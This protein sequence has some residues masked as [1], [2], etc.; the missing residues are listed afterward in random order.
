[1]ESDATTDALIS[2]IQSYIGLG[3]LR[4]AELVCQH[5]L[6]E[7]G[8]AQARGWFLLGLIHLH[9]KAWHEAEIALERAISLDEHS[10]ECWHNLSSA[11]E[12]Q[13]RFSEAESCS[14]RALALDPTNADYWFGLGI[15]LS[16]QLKWDEASEAFRGAVHQNPRDIGAWCNLG[17]AEQ[18][19][20]RLQ[21][22]KV[23]Y[24]RGLAL[25]PHHMDTLVNYA[26]LLAV[27]GQAQRSIDVFRVVLE[28][29]PTDREALHNLAL[30]LLLQGRLSEAEDLA[31]RLLGLDDQSSKAW[32]LTGAI[33]MAIGRTEEGLRAYQ[34]SLELGHQP[35]HHSKLLLAL[36][37][38]DDVE[39]NKQ[40]ETHQ[41]W[42]TLHAEHLFSPSGSIAKARF[43]EAGRLR[44]GFVSADFNQHPIGFFAL[45]ALEHLDKT[46]CSITCYYDR[47]SEDEFTE[48]FRKTA[49]LWHTINGLSDEQLVERIRADEIDIL[50][51]LMGHTGKRLLTFARKPAPIQVTWL[52]YVGTTGLT[53][54]DFIVADRFHVQ[55]AEDRFYVERVLCMPNGYACYGPPDDA[56]D[57]TALPALEQ[58]HVTFGCFNNP[59]K[60]G[61][62]ILDAWAAILSRLPTARLMLKYR[63][64]DCSIAQ[65]ELRCQFS[66][67]GIPLERIIF[68]GHSPHRELLTSYGRIDLALDT[69]PYSGG[70]TTCEAL[71]MGVPVIT[72]PG[73]T[74]AGRHSTSHLNNA[75]Y[76]QFVAQDS[77]S[78]IELA[79]EWANRLDD[80][81]VIRRELR[82]RVRQSPLCD[83]PR[84][85]QD[86]LSL[87][88][89]AANRA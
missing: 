87:L 88:R 59:T 32:S 48:R 36:Q 6:V 67:R 45:P 42:N 23:A 82:D 81:A 2:T 13:G 71:W 80:L 14:R 54:M 64:L 16:G 1:M 9:K 75:G 40:L 25:D 76:P 73:K 21:A 72:F 63:G 35:L 85:A 20:D 19:C 18:R 78:Y 52:G 37:Y 57:V 65:E 62:H 27:I 24:E 8:P 56:P 30:I 46:K 70:L 7:H 66:N 31:R 12:E 38:L 86:F 68:E 77:A 50:V 4:E 5:L 22:A 29:E 33:L 49:D 11:I 69:Q 55:P 26:Y 74:F 83:A 61:H 53:T 44:L 89:Q 41:Q 84:F 39:P 51:D 28:R 17:I 3:Q 34:R 43:S 47:V 58:G 10:A 15:T 60:Y 79:I